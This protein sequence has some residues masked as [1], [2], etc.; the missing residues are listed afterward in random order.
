MLRGYVSHF[1]QKVMQVDDVDEKLVLTT[2]MGGLLP[3]KFIFSFFKSPPSNMAKLM[4]Q[5][6]KYMNVENA[7]A[8]RRDQGNKLRELSKRKRDE[9]PKIVEGEARTRETV[10]KVVR[11]RETRAPAQRAQVYTPFNLPLEQV[12]MHVHDDSSLKWS[13]KL[14]T[15]PKKRSQRKYCR[16]HRDHDHNIELCL[17]EGS[18]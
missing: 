4:L 13:E 9:P 5:T 7:M 16:F 18:D 12:F 1:N 15:P 17:P 11:P 14:K 3:T 6:Q 8:A 10:D 2:F